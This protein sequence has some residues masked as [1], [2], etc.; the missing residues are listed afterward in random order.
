MKRLL[1]ITQKVDQNDDV[2]GFFHEWLCEFSKSL[3]KLTIICLFEG[4]HNLPA[5]TKV[6]SLGKEKRRSKLRYLFNLFSYCWRLRNDYDAVFVHMNP[7]YVI[8]AGLLWRILGKK[9]S[10]WYARGNTNL[11]LK[12]ASKMADVIFTSTAEGFRVKSDKVKIVGQGINTSRFSP[13][14]RTENPVFKIISIGRM[15]PSKDYRTIIKAVELLLD[16]NKKLSVD[17]VGG[18]MVDSDLAY[19]AQLKELVQS[20][21][22]SEQIHFLGSVANKDIVPLL[23]SADLFVNTSLT[24]SLDKAILEAMACGLPVLTCNEAFG[25]ILDK[26][27]AKLIFDPRDTVSLS[28]KIEQFMDLDPE[29]KKKMSADLRQTVIDNHNLSG[30]IMK[31]LTILF[32]DKDI[33][34]FFDRLVGV[35]Y[36]GEYEYNRWF[37]NKISK[38]GFDMTEMAIKRSFNKLDFRD[39]LEV[40]PGPGT[41]TRYFLNKWPKANFDLVDASSEMLRLAENKLGAGQNIRYIH[42]DFDE[43]E[44]DKTYDF[45]FS[46]RALE[47]FPDKQLTVDKICKML[48]PR[49]RGLIITKNPRYWAYKLNDKDLPEIHKMQISPVTLE[50]LFK[51]NNINDVTM[52]PATITIPVVKSAFL[53]K[54][55]FSIF[56]NFKLNFLSKL[57][58]ESYCLYFTKNDH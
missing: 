1:I 27:R 30:L 22:L 19:F 43:F 12:I 32:G 46:S 29:Q 42:S 15:T 35:K 8:Y 41:W 20:N 36:S 26:Y 10:L 49:A 25:N 51:K 16:K 4:K 18:P 5:N 11:T 55:A 17:I 50:E 52:Y 14:P 23:R 39:Y 45:F 56:G 28:R 2:L 31:I 47:Y 13:F 40:G 3:D 7:G 58:A 53:N 37:K 21:R 38:A 48:K 54:L 57:L 33:S 44:S 9:I 34:Q 24:G 6:F